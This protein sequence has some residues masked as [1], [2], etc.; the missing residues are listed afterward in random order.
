MF[1]FVRKM[2][3]KGVPIDGVGFQ[4]HITA[5]NPP[6][7]SAVWRNFKRFADLGLDIHVTELDVRIKGTPTARKLGDQARIYADL[8]KLALSFK[9]V[10]S[11]STWGFTDRDSWVPGSFPGYGTA[12]PF[13]S[14]YNPKPAFFAMQKVLSSGRLVLGEKDFSS[15][16]LAGTSGDGGAGQPFRCLKAATAPL[17]NGKPDDQAWKTS[18]VY[19]FC[20]NQLSVSNLCP[21]EKSDL[22]GRWRIVH[23]GNMI[24]GLVERNDDRTV[25]DNKEQPWLNDNVEVFFRDQGVFV[26]L[27]S[28][29]GAAFETNSYPGKRECAW[30]ADGKVFEFMIQLSGE[31][32]TGRT[33][34]WN[35]G[36]SDNDRGAGAERKYQLYP[37]NGANRG[38]QGMDLS[39]LECE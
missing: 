14:E 28:V 12:L 31:D 9:A 22:W 20:Y 35:I 5:E 16:A 24:Y 29:V 17:V 36:L 23:A 3:A 1:E 18:I 27:R 21:P 33:I 15:S 39:A 19:P 30:S 26:Q 25:T 2:K 32:L 11:F 6:D 38:W 13:D 34:G 8:L 7:L 10:A 37:V 4:F